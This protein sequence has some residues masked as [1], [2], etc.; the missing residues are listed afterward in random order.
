MADLF[1]AGFKKEQVLD[2]LRILPFVSARARDEGEQA[3]RRATVL[4]VRIQCHHP[5]RVEQ[6]R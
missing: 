2:A 1:D 4:P 5:R 6:A 3:Y